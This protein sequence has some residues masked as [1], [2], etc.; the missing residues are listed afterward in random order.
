MDFS[1]K[2]ILTL[3]DGSEG[4]ISQVIGLAQEFSNNITSIQTKLLFPWSKLQPGILPI[5]SW[6]FL[7]NI[8][9]IQKPDI[10]VSCGRKSVYLSIFLKKKYKDLVN[11]H[12]QNP[13]IKFDNFNYIIAPEHDG[14]KG[15]NIIN[16]I[17][18][19]NKFNKSTINNLSDKEF[20]IPKNNLVSVIVGGKNNHYEF[21]AKETEDLIDN[22]TNIKQKNPDYNILII[23]SRRT[24]E[25]I[26]K[27]LDN[28]L[29]KIALIWKENEKN[30]YVFSLKNS[31]FFIVTSDSTSMIS[32]CASTGKPIFVFHLPF[33]RQ[34]KRIEKFHNTFEEK[35]ITKKLDFQNKLISW[36]YNSLNESKRISSIL[37]KRIIKEINES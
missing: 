13:K 19:L 9:L 1:K 7:N 30:P 29:N 3:T 35:K 16:S 5:F 12:I 34:S 17:G 26:K 2:N 8:N 37:K 23:T 28:K 18:A 32:E 27:L 4:M 31:D 20:K 25:K 11:I 10:I 36:S 24:N 33:K 14:I 22:I 15:N 6:I 21:S